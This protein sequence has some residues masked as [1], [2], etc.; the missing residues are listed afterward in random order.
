MTKKKNIGDRFA[1]VL[2]RAYAQTGQRCVVL[3]DEYDKPLLDVIDNPQLQDQ[4]RKVLQSFYSVLKSCDKYLRFAFLT[5]VTKMGSLNI[6]SGLNGTMQ[7]AGYHS[8]YRF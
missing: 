5:G 7:V 2:Q 4:Y 8:I 6:F 3:I 1:N